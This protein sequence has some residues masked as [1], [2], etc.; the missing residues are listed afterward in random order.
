MQSIGTKSFYSKLNKLQE[1]HP[2]GDQ[3]TFPLLQMVL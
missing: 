2:P 1:W 3:L